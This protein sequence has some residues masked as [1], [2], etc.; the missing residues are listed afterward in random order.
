MLVVAS[1][2]KVDEYSEKAV[3]ETRKTKN[4]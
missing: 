1:P 4:K 2:E 3:K